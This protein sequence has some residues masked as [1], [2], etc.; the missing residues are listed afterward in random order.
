[1][2]FAVS[3]VIPDVVAETFWNFVPPE[4]SHKCSDPLADRRMMNLCVASTTTPRWMAS[5]LPWLQAWLNV[6][7]RVSPASWL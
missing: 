6:R 5:I 2:V 7:A 4:V 1:V 3:A